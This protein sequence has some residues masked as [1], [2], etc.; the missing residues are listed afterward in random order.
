MTLAVRQNILGLPCLELIEL[1]IAIG[2]LAAQRHVLLLV[3][4]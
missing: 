3:P 4:A 2:R 1:A